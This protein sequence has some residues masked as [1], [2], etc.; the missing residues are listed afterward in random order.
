[1][2]FNIGQSVMYAGVAVTI[3]SKKYISKLKAW[4]YEVENKRNNFKANIA[5]K[6]LSV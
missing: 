3:I 5:E 2:K 1:M 6:D 4:F